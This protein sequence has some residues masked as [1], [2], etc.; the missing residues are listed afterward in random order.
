M[1]TALSALEKVVDARLQD[2]EARFLRARRDNAGLKSNM[3]AL[4]A[5]IE[6]LERR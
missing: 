3:A 6:R 5:E 1:A 2:W 4:L